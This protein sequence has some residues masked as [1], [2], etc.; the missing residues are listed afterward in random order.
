MDA[1]DSCKL[2]GNMKRA[3]NEWMGDG[4]KRGEPPPYTNAQ[5]EDA[6]HDCQKS[7]AEV[8]KAGVELEFKPLTSTG[9]I[10]GK[11]PKF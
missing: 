7:T 5:I 10:G 8:G 4:L 9:S 11:L 2:V 3:N 6:W 1:G